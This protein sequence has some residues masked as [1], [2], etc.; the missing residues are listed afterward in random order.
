[1]LWTEELSRA[2][3]FDEFMGI[4]YIATA[5]TVYPGAKDN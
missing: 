4:S 1:M 3:S 5:S 2:L